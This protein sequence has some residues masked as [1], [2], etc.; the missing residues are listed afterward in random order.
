MSDKGKNKGRSDSG[1]GKNQ[2]DGSRETFGENQSDQNKIRKGAEV[3]PR[4]IKPESPDSNSE[5]K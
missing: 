1:K 4:P 5:K 2:S 3:N